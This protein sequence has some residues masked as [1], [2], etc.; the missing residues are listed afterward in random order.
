MTTGSS[1]NGT[2]SIVQISVSSVSVSCAAR[3]FDDGTQNSTRV[4]TYPTAAMASRLRST[5]DAGI[6]DGSI[7]GLSFSQATQAN[8]V[9]AILPN[10]AADRIRE[11][12]RFYDWDRALGQVRWM[13]AFDTTEADVDAFAAALHEELVPSRID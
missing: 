12:V 3:V 10:D 13:C 2:V 9:F 4:T 1:W 5:L 8:A 6:A 7:T 11:R